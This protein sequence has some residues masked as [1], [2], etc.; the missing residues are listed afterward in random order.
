MHF[1]FILSNPGNHSV[2]NQHIVITYSNV[3]DE[4]LQV[5]QEFVDMFELDAHVSWNDSITHLIVK[6]QPAGR[7]I[8]TNKFMNA[9][10]LNCFIVSMEWAQ[11]CLSSRTLL[12]EV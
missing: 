11:N 2:S 1:M 10:L 12:P 8:R 6:T 3:E 5:L 7:C 9:L 4:E